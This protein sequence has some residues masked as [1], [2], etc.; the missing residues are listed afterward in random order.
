MADIKDLY[1]P[2]KALYCPCDATRYGVDKARDELISTAK[3]LY[4]VLNADDPKNEIRQIL[5]SLL[6]PIE[7]LPTESEKDFQDRCLEFL[8]EWT[9]KGYIFKQADADN[10]HVG[11]YDRLPDPNAEN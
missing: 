8:T 5:Y 3:M 4:R 1:D 2:A 10:V 6:E 9:G 11:L 7:M